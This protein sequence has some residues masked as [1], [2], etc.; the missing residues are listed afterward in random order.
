MRSVV[1]SL[2]VLCGVGASLCAAG[3]VSVSNVHLCCASCLAAVDEALDGVDGVSGVSADQN[4]KIIRFVAA[5]E[6]AAQAGIDALAR[7]GFFGQAK[8]AGKKIEF[9][10]SGAKAGEK[11]NQIVLYGVHLCCGACVTGAKKSLENVAGLSEIQVDRANGK[12][13]LKGAGIEVSK[14]VSALNAG[15]FYATLKPPGEE[16]KQRD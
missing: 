13:T 6:A 9:P 16:K 5:D 15:G 11:S 2:T 12:I 4:T 14:A 10:T 8:H 7:H 1:C 3:E